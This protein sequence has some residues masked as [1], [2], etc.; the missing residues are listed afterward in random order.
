MSVYVDDMR[1][2][3]QVGQ[4]RPAVWS[5]M[6]AD[7]PAELRE[8]ATLLGLRASWIQW[9]GTHREH[10]DVTDT[11]R[12]KAVRLGALRITYPRGTADL[13]AQRRAAPSVPVGER[14]TD[15]NGDELEHGTD[16][17]EPT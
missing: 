16:S 6:F 7:T 8:F 12:A 14:I 10:F 5:H 11:V 9:E 1:R 15:A 13:L 3:A 4:G 2:R 17:E